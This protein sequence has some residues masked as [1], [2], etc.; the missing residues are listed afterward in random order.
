[1]AQ[2]ATAACPAL[3]TY[4]ELRKA[5]LEKIN[6]FYGDTLRDYEG[7]ATAASPANLPNLVSSYNN[8]LKEINKDLIRQL[9][10]GLDGLAEQYETLKAKNKQFDDNYA[11]IKDLKQAI[12]DREVEVSAKTK[13]AEETGQLTESTRTLHMVF[14]GLNVTLL[15]INI[16]ILVYLFFFAAG[17]SS[18]SPLRNIGIT[19][20]TLRIPKSLNTKY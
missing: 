19:N 10:G 1:M 3:P 12:K 5:N 2:P 4:S 6:K 9:Q 17:G 13:S 20:N 7:L 15:L 18:R 14:L 8:Q 16:G 11:T